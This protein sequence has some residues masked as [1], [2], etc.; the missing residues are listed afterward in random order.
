M[1]QSEKHRFWMMKLTI[2][3]QFDKIISFSVIVRSK[4]LVGSLIDAHRVRSGMQ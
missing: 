4:G 1:H 3:Y 2:S